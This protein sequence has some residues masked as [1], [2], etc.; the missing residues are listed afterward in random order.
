MKIKTV[1]KA[2]SAAGMAGLCAILFIG[3]LYGK[4]DRKTADVDGKEIWQQYAKEPVTLDWYVN[5]SWFTTPWG[6]NAVSEK[7]TEETGVTVHFITPMGNETEKL[8]ALIASDS[9]PDLITIGY[10]EPQVKTIIESQMVYSLNELAED[11]DIYFW[12]D[13]KED[14]VKWY[15]MEDGNIYGYPC[16]ATTLQDYEE[17]KESMVSNQTFV[18]RKDI[19]EAIGSPDMSTQEGFLEAV[20]KAVEMF[21]E[22]NGEKL[23]PVGAHVFDNEGNPSFD[24][25]LMN[26]L[27]VPWEKDGKMY[28]RYTDEEYLSWLK[29]FRKLGEK[30]LLSNDIFVDTRT[31]MEE[32][33]ESGRY[34]CMIYQW[35]D[36][37]A[38]QKKLYEDNPDSIY[39]AVDGPKNSRGDDPTLPVSNING[40]T[41]TMISKN[42]KNP[43][44]AL[45]FLQ[46][47]ISEQGQKRVYLGVEGETYRMVNGSPVWT[48]EAETL[49]ETDREAFDLKYGADDAYWMLQDNVMQS[50]WKQ[51]EPDYIS[52]MGDWTRKYTVYNGQYDVDL[53]ISKETAVIDDECVRLWSR[54]LPELLLAD[55]E[56]EFDRIF[57]SFLEKRESLGYEKVLDEKTKLMH[58]AKKKL[59]IS[60]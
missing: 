54:T 41:I 18:V 17:K 59:G 23:I 29:F 36:L 53:F 48:R 7:I 15:T 16:S 51:S 6:N 49:L 35:A 37:T 3:A 13:T 8:N 32:K 12:K 10:W 40:W 14:V 57:E 43:D 26:F 20:E 56:E 38:Q 52:Q 11:Y 27:A 44:R 2:A 39:I 22:V 19:Y 60:E 28:D 33:L 45:A 5:Y 1:K 31:Q 4:E 55:S 42:C 25:Y 21:P 34:F 50:Q 58:E 30:G 46:Y 9:L 24:K 47:L